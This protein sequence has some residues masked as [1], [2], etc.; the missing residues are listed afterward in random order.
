[1]AFSLEFQKKN[2][3]NK[4]QNFSKRKKMNEKKTRIKNWRNLKIRK[5]K[6]TQLNYLQIP[7]RIF[8]SQN[9]RRGQKKS[10]NRET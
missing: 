3:E 9:S 7:F 1:M 8:F 2:D 10:N 5:R 4:G 6:I